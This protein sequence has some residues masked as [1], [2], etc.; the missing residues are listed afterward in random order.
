MD[1]QSWM[2]AGL[3]IGVSLSVVYLLL[4][5]RYGWFKDD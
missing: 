5:L 4:G 2:M 1:V 3:A